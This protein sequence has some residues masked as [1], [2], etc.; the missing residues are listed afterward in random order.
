MYRAVAAVAAALLGYTSASLGSDQPPV[1]GREGLNAT[2]WMQTAHEYAY[3]TAQV[4]KA[5]DAA[6]STARSRPSALADPGVPVTPE[7]AQA[8][9]VLD[10]DETV[11][12]NS[13]YQA[14]L[15]KKLGWFGRQTWNSWVDAG[16]AGLVAGALDFL[17]D[18]AAAGYRIF[19]VT[20]RACPDTDR[21]ERYPHPSCPQRVATIALAKRLGLPYAD[22]PK[23]FLFRNDQTAWESADK[24]A[25]RR[26]IAEQYK[27]KVVMLLGDDLGDFLTGDQVQA[28]RDSR[29][30]DVPVSDAPQ[31]AADPW[32]G[33]FGSQ[34]FLLPNPVYGSWER[35]L[36]GCSETDKESPRC[37]QERDTA[38]YEKLITARLQ[39]VKSI[40]I[41][42]W[43]MD[44]LIRPEDF[45]VMAP[46]CSAEQPP[47]DVRGI[48]C[49]V[50][51]RS[52]T[53]LRQLRRYADRV[54]KADVVA[55]QEVDGPA[56]A[57][58]VF[59]D[60]NFCF[61]DR[62]HPQKTGFA[63]RQ[64][65]PFRCG[66]HLT[67][68]DVNGQ[69]RAGAVVTLFPDTPNE[70]R[71]LSV[72]LKSGCFTKPLDADDPVCKTLRQQVGILERWLDAQ[73]AAREPVVILGDF[74]RHFNATAESRP[75]GPDDAPGALFNAL[76]DNNP[77]GAV[78][79][80]AALK[81][82]GGLDYVKCRCS[83]SYTDYIDAV[84]LDEQA[85]QR[86]SLRA[87][88]RPAYRQAPFS[89]ETLSD[90]CPVVQ[91]LEL[92]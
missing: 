53:D 2:L 16:E 71:L 76:S 38:K 84:V 79:H 44:W 9:I 87:F 8:A 88:E 78:L 40:R 36:A 85:W 12:D 15:V 59:P 46:S 35:A 62:A 6:L 57:A 33:R 68:L 90:H 31:A 63:L 25:R 47:S 45:A 52:E 32:R 11:L 3:S 91:T 54:L 17:Q 18:A 21:P 66:P 75:G 77:A 29:S 23:A 28:L 22:D 48:P 5:A 89:H 7:D 72:H 55:L 14:D 70:M 20:N 24:S 1:D 27:V 61:I 39:P 10:L 74:N 34:W 80:T 50:R 49:N 67:A 26:F 92:E 60:Y 82:Q 69:S 42:S 4:Y 13:R 83:E 41:A 56:P 65:I 58:E 81:R 43:N 51:K 19:Y 86:T 37:Y 64:G 30:V 73:E